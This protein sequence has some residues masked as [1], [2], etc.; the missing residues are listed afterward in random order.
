MTKEAN[1]MI[2]QVSQVPN[3]WNALSKA[4]PVETQLPKRP[5]KEHPKPT[6]FQQTPQ[7]S[8]PILGKHIDI[9][10]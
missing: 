9:R 1:E 5:I 3:G 10:I 8:D 2:P 6:L 4:Y 7:I